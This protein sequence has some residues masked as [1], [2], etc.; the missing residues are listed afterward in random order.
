MMKYIIGSLLIILG[1]N[2]YAQ[3]FPFQ[4]HE[5]KCNHTSQQ[6]VAKTAYAQSSLMNKYDVKFYFLDIAVERTSVTV[7]GNVTIKAQVTA[8]TLDT[9][10]VELMN[11]MIV[12]SVKINNVIR[13]KS[14]ASDHIYVPVGTPLTNGNVFTA[15]IYYHGTPP[16]SSSFFGGI[17]NK[18]STSWGNQV[19]YTLSEPHNARVWFPCKQILT[20]KADSSWTFITTSN[21]NMAGSNG[22]LTNVVN[23]AGGKKRFEWKSKYPIDYYLISLSVTQYVEY[24]IYAK[25]AA[26]GGD[27]ILIQNFIYNNPST[28]PYFKTEI[29]KT[30]NFVEKQSDLY[31]LYKFNQ[32]KYG[33]CM[34]PIGGGMEHQTM[35]TQGYFDSFLTAHELGHQWFGDN[36]TCATW[37]DI[38]VN[39]GFASY[40][41]YLM[42][43]FLPSLMSQTA[44]SWMNDAH[45]SVKSQPDGSTYVPIAFSFD[46]NRIFDSRL[47]YDKGAGIIHNLRFEMQNDSMFFKTLKDY[48]NIYANGTA[49]GLDFKQVAQNVSGKNFTDFFNQ[50]YFGEGFPTYAVNYGKINTDTLSLTV[51]QTTSTTIT[52]L[53]KGLVEYK[54]QTTTGDTIL[55]LYQTSNVQTFKVRTKRIPTGLV[56][57]PN[58]WIINNAGSVVLSVNETNIDIP[59]TQLYPNPTADFATLLFNQNGVKKVTIFSVLGQK[60]AAFETTANHHLLDLTAYDNQV[61]MVQI[62]TDKG[63][64]VLK[65]VKE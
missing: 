36:V 55:K 24:N 17:F 7:A 14:Q 28:L 37:N 52:P 15:Q 1:L 13:P 58:N 23:V 2:A 12:D 5:G 22:R 31:G 59:T 21:T 19:T 50:W 33:H 34:A 35:T 64:Q 57:D 46:E 54:L 32:E 9:F 38:W 30:K 56:I 47:T 18:T 49:T 25:P 65:V 44:S 11:Y 3:E 29:D 62:Q 4:K 27:S 20:D 6:S 43:E 16:S 10:A 63:T 53:F 45:N 48:Q 60:V 8:S 41:E 26:M 61:Y 39:E 42:A 40:S 51:T